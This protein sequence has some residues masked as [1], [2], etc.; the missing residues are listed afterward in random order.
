V[1]AADDLV[2]PRITQFTR[3]GRGFAPSTVE[4]STTDRPPVVTLPEYRV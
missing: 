3:A 4:I 2:T 1:K